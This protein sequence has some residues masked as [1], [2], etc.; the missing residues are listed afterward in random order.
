MRVATIVIVALLVGLGAGWYLAAP[1]TIADAANEASGDDDNRGGEVDHENHDY[2]G[3]DEDDDDVAVRERLVA[4]DSEIRIRLTP[5]EV[6]LAGIRTAVADAGDATTM[7]RH[8]GRVLTAGPLLAGQSQLRAMTSAVNGQIAIVA[9]LDKRLAELT[10]GSKLGGQRDIA[11]LQLER[12]RARAQADVL[13]AKRDAA[14]TAL[15]AEWG[16]Q[17]VAKTAADGVAQSL[18]NGKTALLGFNLPPDAVPPGDTFTVTAA[19]QSLSARNMG[20]S[21]VTLAGLPGRG[22]YGYV[23]SLNADTAEQALAP[24][25]PV[26][27]WTDS[28]Q[29]SSGVLVPRSAI[30]WDGNGRWLFLMPAPN[31][32]VRRAITEVVEQADGFLVR[33]IPATTPVVI[34]GAQSLQGERFRGAIPD[35]DED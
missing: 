26:T 28:G 14:R 6:E 8:A 24:G 12:A 10:A 16:A 33:G 17:L 4:T 29:P 35:E 21:P 22:W 18:I 31:E 9:A 11:A 20:P 30:V 19:G 3:E 34:A 1:G 23:D 25:M 13:R 7:V 32:Y 2:D 5:A 27:V 15:E